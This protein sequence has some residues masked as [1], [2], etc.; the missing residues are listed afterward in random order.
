MLQADNFKQW[1]CTRKLLLE[2]F[3]QGQERVK[4]DRKN[5]LT[6]A[7]TESYILFSCIKD[8]EVVL[9]TCMASLKTLP[10]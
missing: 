8:N 7:M 3:Q 1:T 5:Y 9:H 4:R 2:T 6:Y 10:S